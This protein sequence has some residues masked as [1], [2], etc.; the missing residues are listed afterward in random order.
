MCL[1]KGFMYNFTS[2]GV[3]SR[4]DMTKEEPSR[5]PLCLRPSFI[6]I[7]KNHWQRGENLSQEIR[8]SPSVS[9]NPVIGKVGSSIISTE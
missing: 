4:I 5:S 8:A 9:S 3:A 1:A 7:L 6:L 2:R